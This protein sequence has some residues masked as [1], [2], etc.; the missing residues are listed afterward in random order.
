MFRSSQNQ[1]IIQNIEKNKHDQKKN[2]TG[3]LSGGKFMRVLRYLDY[4]FRRIFFFSNKNEE[5]Y[6]EAM[7]T[8]QEEK[9]YYAHVESL[10]KS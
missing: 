2:V 1:D 4:Q 5:N 3:I 10:S 7:K 8:H 6:R 9:N